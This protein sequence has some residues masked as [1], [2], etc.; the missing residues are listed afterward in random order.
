MKSII[1]DICGGCK[2]FSD[3]GNTDPKAADM[4][5]ENL[6]RVKNLLCCEAHNDVL[7]A[8]AIGCFEGREASLEA[9]RS[10]IEKLQEMEIPR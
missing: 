6:P 10:D 7:K 5:Y 4:S 2:Y 8:E 9:L 3:N 1:A